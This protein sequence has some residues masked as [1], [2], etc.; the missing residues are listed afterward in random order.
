MVLLDVVLQIE[1][2]QQVLLL[3]LEVLQ[4]AGDLVDLT[5]VVVLVDVSQLSLEVLLGLHHRLVVHHPRQLAVVLLQDGDQ[6]LSLAM[7][8]RA[9]FQ[10]FGNDRLL[11]LL[12][13]E[14]VQVC[15]QVV[16]WLL[17]CSA[18][19]AGA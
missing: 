13:R 3:A 12:V 5:G 17:V 7:A 14:G 1:L 19:G 18:V 6:I 9:V 2:L 4:D 16:G 15:V 8:L 10:P 11:E